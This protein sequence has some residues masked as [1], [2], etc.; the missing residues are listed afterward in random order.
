MSGQTTH[1]TAEAW[2]GGPLDPDPSL[3]E[4]VVRYLG[5]FGPAGVKDV[6]A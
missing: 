2:L 1:T 6:Q 3:E 4:M 5:A